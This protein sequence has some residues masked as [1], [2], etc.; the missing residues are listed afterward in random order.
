MQIA[1]VLSSKFHQTE[2]NPISI[3]NAITTHSQGNGNHA[4]Y[5]HGEIG[6]GF[7]HWLTYIKHTIKKAIAPQK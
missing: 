2:C 4:T 5:K 7:E 1:V 6:H 3:T